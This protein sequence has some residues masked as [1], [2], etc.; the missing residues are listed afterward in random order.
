MLE[1]RLVVLDLPEPIA[2]FFPY[3]SGQITL[4]EHGIAGHYR[5]LKR[6]QIQQGQSL[7]VFV[8][9]GLHRYLSPYGPRF[10]CVRSQQMN[11]GQLLARGPT[12]RLAID[13]H[14]LPAGVPTPLHPPRKHPLKRPNVQTLEQVVKGRLARN[15]LVRKTQR[16]RKTPTTIPSKLGDAL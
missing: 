5:V 6:D 3:C 7:F 8:G 15:W 9:G 2:P 16:P 1:P 10:V 13:G 4:T 12:K 11:T 14:G